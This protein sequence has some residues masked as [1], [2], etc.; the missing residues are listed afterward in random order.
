MTTRQ[1]VY[2]AIDAERDYQD[3]LPSTRTDGLPHTVGDYITMLAY[4]Q[5]QLVMNWTLYAGDYRALDAMRKIA[6]IAVHC[7][8]DHGVIP[9]T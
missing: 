3:A 7:M 9:R 8:E 4:Y 6:G 2:A 1:E 5:Q